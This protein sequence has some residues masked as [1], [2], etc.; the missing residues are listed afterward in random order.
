[1]V[2][3]DVRVSGELVLSVCGWVGVRVGVER[4]FVWE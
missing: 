1:V 2:V 4:E 3:F